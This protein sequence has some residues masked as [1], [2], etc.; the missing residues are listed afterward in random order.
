MPK[1]HFNNDTL[2]PPSLTPGSYEM[3]IESIEEAVSSTN[4]PMLKITYTCV[5]PGFDGRK[6]WHNIVE[7]DGKGGYQVALLLIATG[8]WTE[9][10]LLGQ[11]V[12]FEYADLI[13]KHVGVL[14]VP[15]T[16]NGQATVNV[17]QCV[18]IDECTGPSEA[19]AAA[20]T[21]APKAASS[22]G[23]KSGGRAGS[24]M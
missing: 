18:P 20:P 17:K 4:K 11:D 1:F 8:D 21:V 13:G 19:G 22:T 9:Q 2:R 7:P 24:L 5:M 16:Y 10:E 12:A 15:S 6:A 14:L 3:A 23:R